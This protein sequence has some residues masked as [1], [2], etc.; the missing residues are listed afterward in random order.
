MNSRPQ[1]GPD[2][3]EELA[4]LLPAPVERDLPA[5]RHRLLKGIM[6]QQI[7]HDTRPSRLERRSA[8][9]RPILLSSVLAA[10]AALAVAVPVLTGGGTPAYAVSRNPDGTITVEI[11][12]VRDPKALEADL[13]ALGF[14]AV[15]DYVPRGK[16]CED[17]RSDSLLPREETYDPADGRPLVIP[18]GVTGPEG[19]FLFDPGALDDG[20]T[21]VLEFTL[22]E[23]DD[24]VISA[25]WARISN[26]PVKPCVLV[27]STG[28][29]LGPAET[30][31]T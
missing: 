17:P 27:D 10:A 15:V 8:L 19:G 25:V 2:Q 22:G 12:E 14:D 28:H 16:Q 30:P 7:H 13:N 31:G 11:N 1:S 20:Q 3:L 18:R 4:R 24:A 5:D 6:M 29:P 26:G 21:A 9:R 23:N